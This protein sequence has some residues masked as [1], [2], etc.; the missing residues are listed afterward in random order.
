ML[1]RFSTGHSRQDRSC[2]LASLGLAAE[3]LGEFEQPL[4]APGSAVEDHV[5]AGLAQLRIDVVID[6]QLAGIDD[7]HV[8]ARLMA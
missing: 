2:S 5:L 6:D 1:S 3:F 4:G 8:H 7:A